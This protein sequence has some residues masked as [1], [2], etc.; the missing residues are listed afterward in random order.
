MGCF[1]PKYII[2]ELKKYKGAIFNDTGEWF[3]IWRGTDLSVQNWHERIWR[4][5]TLVLENLK[6]CTSMSCFWRKYIMCELKKYRGVMLEW[7][8]VTLS[9]ALKNNAKFEEKPTRDFKNDMKNLESF[10]TGWKIAIKF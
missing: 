5:L 9:Y 8:Y 6:Y 7:C 4:I 2:S 3:K 10:L 1:W